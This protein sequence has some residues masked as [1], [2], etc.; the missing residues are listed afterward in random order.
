MYSL[1]RRQLA[2]VP[3]Q[4]REGEE[5]C[6]YQR[7]YEQL[8]NF[9]GSFPTD[10]SSEITYGIACCTLFVIPI[11]PDAPLNFNL[12]SYVFLASTFHVGIWISRLQADS[13]TYSF[14]FVATLMRIEKS[15]GNNSRR[16][17]LLW[18]VYTVRVFNSVCYTHSIPSRRDIWVQ[19]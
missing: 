19:H 5:I 14:V 3:K 9:F 7:E 12:Q 18:R 2:A 4:R 10:L 17:T 15:S 11:H 6:L 1:P 8:M 13:C 16:S